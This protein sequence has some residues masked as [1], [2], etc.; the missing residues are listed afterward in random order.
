MQVEPLFAEYNQL[1]LI[2]SE[3][4]NAQREAEQALQQEH[5]RRQQFNLQL[6][7]NKT[8]SDVLER[9]IETLQVEKATLESTLSDMCEKLLRMLLRIFSASQSFKPLCNY[10]FL[11]FE[12]WKAV[13]DA[14][15]DGF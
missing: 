14:P 12:Q 13:D 4:T 10:V 6:E 3:A 7:H 9:Q 8:L 1:R 2:V 11:P 5:R 15:R